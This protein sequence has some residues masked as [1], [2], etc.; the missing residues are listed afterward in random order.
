MRVGKT[1]YSASG[2]YWAQFYV[3]VGNQGTIISSPDGK[4]WLHESS[5]TSQ[6]LLGVAWSQ[7]GYF[8]NQFVSVGDQGTI[9]TAQFRFAPVLYPEGPSST[10]DI[11][12]GSKIVHYFLSAPTGVSLN[13][14]N[15]NGRLAKALVN[16]TQASGSHAAAIPSG[17]APGSYVLSL[18][19]GNVHDNKPFVVTEK[20]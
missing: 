9:L 12:L 6:N 2:L 15:I 16:C 1:L 7:T 10:H 14:Y 20:N 19:A 17:L 18:K 13:I 5:G 8:G 4:K 11:T 3:A